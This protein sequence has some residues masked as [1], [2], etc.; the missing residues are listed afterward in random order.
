MDPDERFMRLAIEKALEGIAK[1]QTP[2]G[3]CIVRGGEVISCEHN[4]VWAEMDITAHA[5]IH[6]IRRACAALRTVDSACHWARVERIVFGASIRDAELYGFNELP[7][8]NVELKHLGRSPVKIRSGVLPSAC[9]ELFRL[10][11]QQ[12]SRRAY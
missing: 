7:V 10:W 12:G 6:A 1:G 11:S 8:G 3:A 4:V 2:F 5:E 9:L